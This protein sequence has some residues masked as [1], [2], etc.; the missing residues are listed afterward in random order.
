MLNLYSL[1]STE[2]GDCTSAV[3]LVEGDTDNSSWNEMWAAA[4]AVEEIC[5]KK[6]KAGA[7]FGLG[8]WICSIRAEEKILM[9]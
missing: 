8:E 5:V 3:D 2:S 4:V 7:A 1:L 9:C 6:G